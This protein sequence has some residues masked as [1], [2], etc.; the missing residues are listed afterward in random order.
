MV[1][2]RDGGSESHYRQSRRN[3]SEVI[4]DKDGNTRKYV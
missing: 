1:I 3:K 4:E 2:F